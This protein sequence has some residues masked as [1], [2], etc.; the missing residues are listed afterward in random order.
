MNRSDP[1]DTKRVGV[2]IEA[3]AENRRRQDQEIARLEREVA[4]VWAD[5]SPARNSPETASDENPLLDQIANQAALDPHVPIGSRRGLRSIKWAIRKL[6]YWYIRFLSDQ[7]NVFAGMLVRH[8]RN[9]ETRLGRLEDAAGYPVAQSV[10]AGFG[11]LDN[12]PEPSATVVSHVAGFASS[13]PCLVISGGEGDIVEAIGN[14]GVLSHG[15]E[16]EPDRVLAGLKRQLDIRTGDVLAHLLDA[17]D[18]SFGTI[19]LTGVV[20]TLPLANLL[21]MVDQAS[22]K[23]DKTGR[24]IVAV[25]DPAS[26]G[27]VDAELGS[28]LGI[29]P[30]TWRH[31]LQ[32]IG[33]DA[34]LEPCPDSRIAEIVVAQ[35]ATKQSDP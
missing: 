11:I 26:R 25:A 18:E 12:P 7:F 33:F 3:K 4:Q 10:P 9:L 14:R 21:E 17:E 20:E 29:S 5:I 31:L 34:R 28:G 35:R 2:E 1:V 15:V 24:I 27:R 23:L 8:L 6:T 19:V 30:I 22:R 16:Q 32:G 13:G